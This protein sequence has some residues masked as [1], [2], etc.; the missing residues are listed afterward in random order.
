M[1]T[2]YEHIHPDFLHLL[3]LDKEQ[4]CYSLDEFFMINYPKAN[5]TLQ[6]MSNYMNKPRKYR[7]QNLLIIGEPNM[8]KTTISKKFHKM[9][10]DY[11]MEINDIITTIK[12]I[13]Y[14]NV[15]NSDE[16]ELYTSILDQ[17]WAPYKLSHSKLKLK[18]QAIHLLKTCKVKTIILDEIHNILTGSPLKQ[19][20][21]MDCIK[22]LSNDL[23]IPIIGVGTKAAASLLYSNPQLVSRFDIIKLEKWELDSN[24]RG[25][26]QSFEK[27]LPLKKPS[28]LISK[29][30]A[31][32]L[33]DLS[34]GN[35]GHL[36]K[37][38]IA[39]A[40][41]AI[42]NDIEEITLDVIEKFFHLKIAKATNPKKYATS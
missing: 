33:Y 32:L 38:L 42:K 29:E 18:Q 6:I 20:V 3:G 5:E 10:P 27:R 4:R 12:P 39:C 23:M 13:I 7:M 9:N 36:H 41:Y 24:F 16:K 31:I 19:E 1:N 37:I 8:G 28:N 17:F 26:L 34:Q 30:K 40:D 25:L 15:Q 21:I 22:N 14:V 2:K 35:L 11:Q